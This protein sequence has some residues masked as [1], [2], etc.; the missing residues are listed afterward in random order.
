[1]PFFS[2]VVPAYNRADLIVETIDSVLRQT[3][4]DFEIVV[5]DD[6]STDDTPGVMQK[7]FASE[8]KLR[9]VRQLNAERGAARNNGFKQSRG[10]YVVFFDSDDLMHADHLATLAEIIERYPDVNFLATNYDLLRDGKICPSSIS[11]LK[12]GWHG[13]EIFLR[14]NPLACNVCVRKGN[15]HLKLFVE[16]RRYAIVE[17]WIFLAENIAADKIYID[18]RTTISLVDH[19]SRSMRGD[20]REIIEK[21][22]LAREWLLAKLDLSAMQRK[23][24]EGHSEYFCAVHSY[25]DDDRRS[26]AR[27]LF[28]AAKKLGVDFRLAA[29]FVKSMVGRSLVRKMFLSHK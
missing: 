5:V 22:L 6:G 13:I 14:G 4:S 26:A 29:L 23:I 21:H 12:E 25:L 9:Y 8:E 7:H 24:L 19:D 18:G 11:E 10:L 27:H 3:Y 20:N 16:D 15:E 2:V 1:M 28:N 17:D